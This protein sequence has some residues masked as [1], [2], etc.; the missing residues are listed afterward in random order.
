MA[1]FVILL[2]FSVFW[3]PNPEWVILQFFVVFRISGVE[4]FAYSVARRGDR[5]S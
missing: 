2:Y 3:G 5:N 4:G 1:I